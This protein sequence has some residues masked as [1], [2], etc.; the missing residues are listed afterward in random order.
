MSKLYTLHF[1]LPPPSIVC[2][3]KVRIV[4]QILVVVCVSYYFLVIVFA[5]RSHTQYHVTECDGRYDN[6]EYAYAHSDAFHVEIV[7]YSCR[8]V[9]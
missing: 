2:I 6:A 9:E 3:S 8:G 1:P 7:V 5:Y 4:T